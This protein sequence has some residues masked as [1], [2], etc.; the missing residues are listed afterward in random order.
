[1]TKQKQRSLQTF[2]AIVYRPDSDKIDIQKI[3]AESYEIAYKH[4][5]ENVHQ[6][7]DVVILS[8]KQFAK[9]VKKINRFVWNV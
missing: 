4:A 9:L 5:A 6:F 7:Y 2:I 3:E 1:M 8:R